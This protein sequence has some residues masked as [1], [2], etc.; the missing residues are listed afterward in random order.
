MDDVGGGAVTP[1]DGAPRPPRRWQAEALPVV[2]DA[3]RRRVRGLVTATMGAGK[4][5]LQAELCH[6]AQ[7]KLGDRVIVC[8]VPREALVRQLA[9]TIGERVGEKR[10]G[11]FYG[12]KKQAGR[13]VIV[14]CNASVPNLMLE[15]AA[16]QRRVALLIADEAHSTEGAVL[17]ECIPQLDPVC[18]VG[19]TATPFRS[20]PSETVSLFDQVLYRYPITDA[21]ADGV[22]VPM[23]HVRV[24]GTPDM[25][26][27]DQVCLDMMREHA[28][29]PGIVSSRDIADAEGYAAWLT[30]QGWSAQAIHS[31]HSQAERDQRLA[32]LQAG[33]VRC[34]VHV[35]LLAE[36]VDFPW[37][38]W[39]CLRR[40]VGAR[41]RF[42][43][44]LGRV[45]RTH[46]GSDKVDGV[47]LDPHLLLGRHGKKL[48]TVEA[49][50]KALQEAADAEV[51]ERGTRGPREPTDE[52][53]VALDI[54]AAFLD[55][56]HEGLLSAGI[57]PP[58]KYPP[59][60]WELADVTERQVELIKQSS[61]FP[62]HIPDEYR[63]PF[64]SMVKI[65]YAWT[66]GQA[67]KIIDALLGGARHV[68]PRIDVEAGIYPNMVQWDARLVRVQIPNHEAILA[69]GRGG[70]K[71]AP[72][73][74]GS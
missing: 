72:A 63:D 47:V 11:Q 40:P 34:L 57:I 37:L 51:Q 59:G 50:G 55:D 68:R 61:R 74:E 23:R 65:P 60:G 32:D 13:S 52:E 71:M 9:A 39:L 70:R 15:L 22:L 58:P 49:I 42:L 56:F 30:D 44:E 54:L 27:L 4:S 2:V 8:T 24:E 64:K 67:S 35:S 3:M 36:G 28:R 62:R 33:R 20:V 17:R 21:V 16:R 46:P 6:L 12:R 26:E 25:L 69:A 18:V 43:Q 41:V 29:G 31:R 5:V 10:V 19:F 7:A 14:A 73:G 38:R 45:L 48:M 1:W 53:A 66:R